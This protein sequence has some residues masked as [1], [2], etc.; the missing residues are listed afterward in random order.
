VSAGGFVSVAR[1]FRTDPV[2]PNWGWRA[3]LYTTVR[4]H[5]ALETRLELFLGWEY[6][7]GSTLY[8]VYSRGQ[9]RFPVADGERVP[10]TLLPTGLLAGPANDA[11]MVKWAWYWGA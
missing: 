4:P 2:A 9:Q 11:L 1:H 7:L 3:D 10:H 8:G 5:P 6:R